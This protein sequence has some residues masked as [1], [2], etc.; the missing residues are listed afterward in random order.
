MLTLPLPLEPLAAFKQFIV[1][2][3]VPKVDRP[4]KVDKIPVHYVTGNKIDAHDPGVWV[5]VQ[6]A[7][8]AAQA[9]NMNVTPPCTGYGVGFVFTD[10]DPF[11]FVDVDGCINNNQWSP[12]A[13]QL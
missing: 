1:Y 4:G 9:W 11:F 12:I 2:K 6:T 5:D 13:L 8:A 7:I 10:A 3:L